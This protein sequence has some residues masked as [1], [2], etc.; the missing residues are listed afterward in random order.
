MMTFKNLLRV[1]TVLTAGIFLLAATQGASASGGKNRHQTKP[2]VKGISSN[3]IKPSQPSVAVRDHRSGNAATIVTGS[4]QRVIDARSQPTVR[5]YR[6]GPS[7]A[8]KAGAGGSPGGVSVT[9]SGPREGTTTKTKR[10][11]CIGNLCGVS[12]S[13]S[14]AARGIGRTFRSWF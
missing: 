9:S 13:I 5:D 1:S 2:P 12:E 10:V 6:T 3:D 8:A 7:A 14:D 11:P 4:G